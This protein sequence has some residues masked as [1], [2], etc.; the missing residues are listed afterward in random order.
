MKL[1]K[2]VDMMLSEDYKERFKAEYHQ[3]VYRVNKLQTIVGKA[4]KGTLDF[5]LTCPLD[6]LERQLDGMQIY[7]KAMKKR[8]EVEKI[9]L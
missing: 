1:D 5:K 3:L 4:K 9:K 7:L 6:L 2:T 8:A